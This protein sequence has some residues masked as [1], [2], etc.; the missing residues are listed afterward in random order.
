MRYR[1]KNME[2]WRNTG[3]EPVE[4]DERS[5]AILQRRGWDLH[6]SGHNAGSWDA[7]QGQ[8]AWGADHYCLPGGHL[9]ILAW[10]CET[11]EKWRTHMTWNHL[12]SAKNRLSRPEPSSANH[13]RFTFAALQ[14]GSL[15]CLHQRVHWVGF[16]QI[17]HNFHILS[18]VIHHSLW[19]HWAGTWRC[20]W[21]TPHLLA[22][23]GLSTKTSS[24]FSYRMV[25]MIIVD[26]QSWK[27]WSLIDQR[28][29]SPD[30]KKCSQRVFPAVVASQTRWER[31][32]KTK[33]IKHKQG[34]REN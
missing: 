21:E 27:N 9:T 17:C 13:R 5:G 30:L 16:H 31:K 18:I 4:P 28:N 12:L 1:I 14:V 11:C 20:M 10:P 33:S 15:Q 22:L 29:L 32:L 34:D 3:R 24:A 6:S 19:W 7:P 23:P 2:Y 25:V 26:H 8:G